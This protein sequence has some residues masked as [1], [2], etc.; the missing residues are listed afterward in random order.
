MSQFLSFQSGMPQNSVLGSLLFLLFI[1]DVSYILTNDVYK[2][3]MFADDLKCYSVS[4]YRINPDI[5]QSKLDAIIHW[6]DTRQ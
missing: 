5:V 1:N 6:S 4:D 2:A 3:M